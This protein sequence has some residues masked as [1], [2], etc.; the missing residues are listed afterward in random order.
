MAT[1]TT[2]PAAKSQQPPDE[3]FWVKYSPHHELPISSMASLTWHVLIG[4]VIVVVG[5]II[6]RNRF[7][8]MPIETVA[9][10][11]GGGKLDGVG[12]ASGLGGAPQVEAATEQELPN[13]IPGS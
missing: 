4:V 12:N 6:T 7:A 5:F 9:W 1:K 10:G 3:R 11:G 8:D 2:P 13:P